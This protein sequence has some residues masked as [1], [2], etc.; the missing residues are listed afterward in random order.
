MRK[1]ITAAALTLL[2]LLTFA[3]TGCMEDKTIEPDT[4]PEI[5]GGGRLLE[6]KLP[7][8]EEGHVDFYYWYY[9]SYAMY[10]L[11]GSYWDKWQRAMEKA[12]V[13]NQHETGCEKGSWDPDVDPWGDVGGRC[14]STALNVLSLEV[15]YRYDR[16]AGAR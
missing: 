3:S 13:Q 15:Y 7:R 4:I 12:I 1:K 10:Q 16:I 6:K 5:K 14:Y 9:G 11:S 8:W 2:F